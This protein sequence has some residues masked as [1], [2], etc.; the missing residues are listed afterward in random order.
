MT[1]E[2]SRGDAILQ[3]LPMIAPGTPLRE[4]LEN[5]LRARTGALI[6][7][8]DSEEVMELVHGGFK[9]DSEM[10][11]F[12]LYELAKMDGAIILSADAKRI[13]YVNA[14]LSPS[15]ALPTVETGMRHQTA[16]RVAR[17]TGELVIAISQRRNVI[18][19]Y[20]G[21]HRYVLRDVGVVLAKANQALSTLEKYK[22]VFEQALTNLS[23]L[24]FE[25]LAT[26]F[27][28][29]TCIQR[30]QMVSRIAEELERHVAELGT[31]GRLV[32]MQLE[33]LMMDIKDEGL[34]VIRDY[35]TG[36]DGRT[37][38]E[39]LAELRACDS[40]ELLDLN[41][42]TRTLGHG[43]MNN[44]DAPVTPRGYRILHKIP[45][46]PANVIE[47]LVRVFNTLP[48]I[49]GASIDELDDV[50]GIGEVRARAI[51]EGLRRLRE[52]VLLDRHL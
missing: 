40:D 26:L 38:E 11:P 10:N 37:S 15:T 52:K 25:D 36:D 24:E 42:I 21:P 4:A 12:A 33:E 43:G 13:L 47:N 7:V 6:V 28:V 20:R 30:A 2:N 50:E 31:E 48:E 3:A 46:L 49:L 17:Q 14:H 39:L 22:S 35:A 29:A 41:V 19:V 18:T 9:I 5:I 44:L 51:K 16:E 8:G 1:D 34:L 23:A 27:D 45:R 32:N